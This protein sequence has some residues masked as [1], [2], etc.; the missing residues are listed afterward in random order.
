MFFFVY[1][2]LVYLVLGVDSFL[3][4]RVFLKVYRDRGFS[5]S[6]FLGYDYVD[7]FLGLEVG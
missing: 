7:M 1:Y 2:R 5:V 3:V 6:R 4:Y